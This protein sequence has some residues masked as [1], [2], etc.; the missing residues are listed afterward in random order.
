MAYW[1]GT[2]GVNAAV[3][4][5]GAVWVVPVTIIARLAFLS[6]GHTHTRGAFR[7]HVTRLES[8]LQ[9]L[10]GLSSH[11]QQVVAAVNELARKGTAPAGDWITLARTSGNHLEEVERRLNALG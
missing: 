10:T 8:F 9:S 11:L 2:A 1:V 5:S 3:P 4:G 7:S 6:Q